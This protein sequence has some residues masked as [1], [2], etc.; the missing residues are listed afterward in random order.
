MVLAT[1]RPP[2]AR[3]TRFEAKAASWHAAS[4]ASAGTSMRSLTFPS[5]WTTSVKDS[6][7]ASTGSKAGHGSRCTLPFPPSSSRHSSS[8]THGPIGAPSFHERHRLD[9]VPLALAHRSAAVD[10]LPLVLEAHERFGERHH[11]HVVQGLGDE[12]RVQE[13]EDG[14]LDA[15]RVLVGGHPALDRAPFEGPVLVPG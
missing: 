6:S 9:H 13:V 10:D 2:R 11:A 12:P 4:S 8:A 14:V 15:S 5:T 7:R 3:W 1:E